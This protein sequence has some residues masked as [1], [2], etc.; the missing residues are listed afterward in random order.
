MQYTLCSNPV[1]PLGNLENEL[2]CINK[3]FKWF[4]HLR[5]E[6]LD[7][8]MLMEICIEQITEIMYHLPI[9]PS[10]AQCPES[11]PVMNVGGS[12]PGGGSPENVGGALGSV[13]P[14]PWLFLDCLGKQLNSPFL[15][16][17][18][19]QEIGCS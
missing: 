6:T 11:Q 15:L 16:L 9:A 14:P 12:V 4:T 13:A 1:L 3:A 17:T 2:F 7:L 10:P 18:H 19:Q 8:K 5:D